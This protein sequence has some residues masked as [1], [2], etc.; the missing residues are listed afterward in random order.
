MK[1][2][3]KDKQWKKSRLYE[4]FSLELE[5]TLP[6]V[7]IKLNKLPPK[8]LLGI[9]KDEIEELSKTAVTKRDINYENRIKTIYDLISKYRNMTT[10]DWEIRRRWARMYMNKID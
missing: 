3:Y 9:I 7:K 6:N 2:I 8:V 5:E 4:E 1:K 10:Q